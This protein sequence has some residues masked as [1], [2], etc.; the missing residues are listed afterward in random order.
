M[1]Y[2]SI[3]VFFHEFKSKVGISNKDP[4]ANE[5]WS[6]RTLPNFTQHMTA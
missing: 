2:I 1:I 6:N 3:S 4:Y 5:L